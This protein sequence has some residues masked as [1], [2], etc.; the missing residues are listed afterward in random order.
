[1]RRPA[2]AIVAVLILQSC[3]PQ[4]GPGPYDV[5]LSDS[6]R[7][8]LVRP[9][10]TTV[11]IS[12]LENAALSAATGRRCTARVAPVIYEVAKNDRSAALPASA[13]S[14]FAGRFPVTLDC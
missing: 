12:G 7:L 5:T 9:K 4:P 14:R 11:T 10:T 8:A 2:L 1:M 3:A 6:G 13:G